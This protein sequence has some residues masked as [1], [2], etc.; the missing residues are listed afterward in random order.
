MEYLGEKPEV[1]ESSR[2]PHQTVFRRLHPL[3]F[4][5]DGGLDGVVVALSG[6]AFGSPFE[7]DQYRSRGGAEACKN[8]GESQHADPDGVGSAQ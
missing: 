6:G 5:C 4:A 3:A 7:R 1:C 8:V 2:E